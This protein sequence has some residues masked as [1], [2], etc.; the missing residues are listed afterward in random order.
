MLEIKIFLEVLRMLF[1]LPSWSFQ[2]NI[3]TENDLGNICQLINMYDI[4]NK[5]NN[6]SFRHLFQKTSGFLMF[7]GGIERG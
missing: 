5:C 2:V 1:L 7:S 6:L 4:H 3:K